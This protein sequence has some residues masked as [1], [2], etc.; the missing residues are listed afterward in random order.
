MAQ[1]PPKRLRKALPPPTNNAENNLDSDK[2]YATYERWIH[3]VPKG[4]RL[5]SVTLPDGTIF[6]PLRTIN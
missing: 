4:S 5:L 3:K 2:Q 1:G 6:R